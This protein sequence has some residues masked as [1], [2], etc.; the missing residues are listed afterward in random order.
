[1][2]FA[3]RVVLFTAAQQLNKVLLGNA[4]QPLRGVSEVG[5]INRL[6]NL[7]IKVLLSSSRMFNMWLVKKSTV[8][9][10]WGSVVCNRI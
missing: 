7:P 10:G 2:P 5:C 1:M 9:T 3:L 6:C 4:P 8:K